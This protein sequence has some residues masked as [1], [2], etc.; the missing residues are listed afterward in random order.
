MVNDVKMGLRLHVSNKKFDRAKVVA[1]DQ[2]GDARDERDRERIKLSKH[3][4]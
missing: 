1:N 2:R 3:R 4:E